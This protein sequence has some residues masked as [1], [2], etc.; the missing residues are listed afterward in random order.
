MNRTKVLLLVAAVLATPV[1]AGCSDTA[2]DGPETVANPQTTVSATADGDGGT[3]TGVD[4]D[5]YSDAE[6]REIRQATI[7][8]LDGVSDVRLVGTLEQTVSDG[9]RNQSRTVD[10]EKTI[11]AANRRLVLDQTVSVQGRT[12]NQTSYLLNGSFYVRSPVLEQQYGSNWVTQNVSESYDRVW[13]NTSTLYM[14]RALLEVSDVQV[15][16][17]ET[18]RGEQAYVVVLRPDQ[19]ELANVSGPN[20]QG[21]QVN[22]LDATMYV[23]TET[24]LVLRSVLHVNQTV[25]TPSGQELTAIVDVE[26]DFL[27]YDEGVTVTL[28][29]EADDAVPLGGNTTNRTTARSVAGIA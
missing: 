12:I 22:E 8:A 25:R 23:S 19:D 1:L 2:D 17:T 6:E 7:A 13:R 9:T 20:F 16:G 26:R 10:F 29:E 4:V 27:A 5:A 18:V 15:T 14:H 24:D 11:D 21:S 3:T 28:P